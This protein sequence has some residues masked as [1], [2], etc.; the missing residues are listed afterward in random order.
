MS[1]QAQGKGEVKGGDSS[2]GNSGLEMGPGV[3]AQALAFL[4]LCKLAD[5]QQ[6]IVEAR[7]GLAKA[8]VSG[9]TAV[10][11]DQNAHYT[12]EMNDQMLS[13]YADAFNSGT[14][15]VVSGGSALYQKMSSSTSELSTASKNA[16]Q[17]ET[18]KDNFASTKPLDGA[19]IGT[20]PPVQ[21][22][23]SG[24]C[25][26]K[27]QAGDYKGAAQ[28]SS[29]DQKAAIAQL[30][31]AVQR[32]MTQEEEGEYTRALQIKAQ[33][34]QEVNTEYT[35]ALQIENTKM[36]GV[37]TGQT[38]LTTITQIL[39]GV[40]DAVT[41]GVKGTLKG[42]IGWGGESQAEAHNQQT[43]DQLK[44]QLMMNVMSDQAQNQQKSSDVEIQMWT[45]YFQA[46]VQASRV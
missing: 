17:M 12:N 31:P 38:R 34:S 46:M 40:T 14:K 6:K 26:Q 29:D 22:P 10:V 28:Y 18:L 27:L 44:Q 33:K 23:A 9:A 30:T 36:L 7:A 42:G 39:Q 3:S 2:Y 13:D 35:R 16:Q 8:S 15:A 20:Q 24:E 5:S 21:T 1:Y 11:E 19:G 43:I 41:S 25:L 4:E 45:N 37:N 32:P